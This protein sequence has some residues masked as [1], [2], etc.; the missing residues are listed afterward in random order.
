[1]RDREKVIGMESTSGR[2]AEG[3]GQV[4]STLST[5]L[6]VSSSHDLEVIT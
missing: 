4:D 6:D 2:G 3:E 1:M 5:E